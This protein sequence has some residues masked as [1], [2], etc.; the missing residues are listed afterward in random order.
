MASG[1]RHGKGELGT[2][3]SR[4]HGEGVKPLRMEVAS[5][6]TDF[7]LVDFDNFDNFDRRQ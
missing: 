3:G 4:N 1:C 5:I 7:A 6:Q 2:S